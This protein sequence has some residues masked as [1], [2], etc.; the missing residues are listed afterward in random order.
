MTA[1][2]QYIS[3]VG[4]RTDLPRLAQ[5]EGMHFPCRRCKLPPTEEMLHAGHAHLGPVLQAVAVDPYQLD[6][7]IATL[8][9]YSLVHR[10]VS[11]KF[12]RIHRLMQA[13][14]R[15]GLPADEQKVWLERVTRALNQVFPT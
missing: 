7:A 9:A 14:L 12:L 15:D 8:R 3:T 2:S 4:Q 1:R 6:Q 5:E 13:I 10:D 11:Y